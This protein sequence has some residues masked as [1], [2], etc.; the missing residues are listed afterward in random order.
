M[1]LLGRSFID[2]IKKSLSQKL[3]LPC[4]PYGIPSYWD[5]VYKSLGP[6]DVFEWGSFDLSEVL[7]HQYN[8]RTYSPLMAKIGYAPKI[9]IKNTPK[10]NYVDSNGLVSTTFGEAMGMHPYE[11][12]RSKDRI[13]II[14]CGNSRFG[15]DMISNGWCSS[16][17]MQGNQTG[18]IT[19]IDISQKVLS[20]M[21]QRC[22][23]YIENGTMDFIHDDAKILSAFEDNSISAAVDKGLVDSL[24]C[25]ECFGNIR[26]IMKS[27]HRVLKP[28]QNFIFFSFSEPE[29]LL[30]HTLMRDP[31]RKMWS[32]VEVRK[33][34]SILM[35][36]Y[37]KKKTMK[38]TQT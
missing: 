22:T 14:G 33:L 12:T 31:K 19:Q 16:K 35:Y 36:R 18:K 34:D 29:Y 28:G 32:R 38:R 7:H 8:E 6:D 25:A 37:E 17:T 11:E 27:V 1:S 4:P 9:K 10:M 26:D 24:F 15:E 3:A 30:H 2:R 21:S 20:S 23:A 13:L 5:G